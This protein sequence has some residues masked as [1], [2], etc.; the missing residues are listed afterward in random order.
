MIHPLA[1][2]VFFGGLRNGDLDAQEHAHRMRKDRHNACHG[3]L[4]PTWMP[5]LRV[6]ER[7]PS[8]YAGLKHLPYSPLVTPELSHT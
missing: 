2:K 5:T 8:L 7:P 4:H 3:Q 1:R 6:G